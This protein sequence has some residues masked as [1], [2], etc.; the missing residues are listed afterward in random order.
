MSEHLTPLDATFLELEQADESAHMHIGGVLVFDPLPDGGPPS[1]EELCQHLASR[2][3]QLPRY[4]Q[5]LSEPHTGGLS[6]PEWEDDPAFD[7]GTH[8]TRAALPAPGGYEELQ[9]WASGFFSQRLDRH[10]PLWEM[11]MVEGLA[12]GRW[13]LAHKTHHSM[14]DGV[15]SVD[16]GH[17]MLDATPDATPAAPCRR[18]P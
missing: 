3:G 9:E 7:I 11:A 16:V 2:L 18:P 8:V 4:G 6:W 14:V 17:L 13:A 15:G 10:R 1:R 12:D 5:R